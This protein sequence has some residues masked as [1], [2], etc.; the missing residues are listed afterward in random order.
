MAKLEKYT[1][2]TL[3]ILLATSAIG[4][5]QL[6]NA[7]TI[8]KPEIPQFTVE[9]VD[10]SHV[11]P[12]TNSVDPYSGETI[13]SGGGSTVIN[14]GL[15]LTIKNQQFSSYYENN[16]FIDLY[17]R[18]GYKGHYEND[19]HYY[20]IPANL[21]SYYTVVW[22]GLVW[23]EQSSPDIRLR[24]LS[25]GD[26]V[27]FKVQ[28]EVGYFGMA[29]NPYVPIGSSINYDDLH[30]EASDWSTVLTY[31]MS[32]AKNTTSSIGPTPTVPELDVTSILP[33]LVI[34]PL[35]TV[36]IVKKRPYLKA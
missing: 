10:N 1:T 12:P 24:A 11:Y 9:F 5:I 29:E 23:D 35:V 19:W 2:L 28:S 6:S 32:G 15:E 26:K 7:R 20:T 22:I 4:I 30:G 18:V 27:D 16:N 33:L 14:K 34:I 25:P 8:T 3:V 21:E 36:F 17:Y 13:Q 31:T